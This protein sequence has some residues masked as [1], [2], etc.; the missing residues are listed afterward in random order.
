MDE[1]AGI[2]PERDA[3]DSE[4]AERAVALAGVMLERAR[5]LDGQAPRVQRKRS[6]RLRLLVRNPR[7]KA[8]AL[9]LSDELMR[10]PD[11][12]R[13]ARRFARLVRQSDVSGFPWSDRVLLRASAAGAE[14]APWLVTPLV[15]S[16][17]RAES[18][19]VILDSS[20]PAFSRHLALRRS[21]G[22]RLNVNVLGEAILGAEE[23][24]AR[25]EQVLDRLRHP[26]V[27][28]VSVKISAI[29]PTV[30]SL[31]FAATVTDVADRLRVLY[32]ACQAV[33]P[34][35][36]VNLDMEEYRDLS[37]TAAAFTA[38]LGEQEFMSLEAGIALQAYLPD[39]HRVAS[40]VVAWARR[41][42]ARG[43]APVKIRL[44][45]GANL[46][47]ERVESELRGWPAAPYADKADVDASY[48]R[49]LDML[50]EPVNDD[51]IR[52]GLASHNLFDVAWGLMLR[53]ELRARGAEGRLEIE[54]L[55]GMAPSQ[56]S[57]ASVL[58]GGMLLYA[59]VAS[60]DDFPAAV[61]YLVRRLDENTLP[62][63]FL[64]HV[65]T[66]RA[67]DD[68]FDAEARRFREAVA[69]RSSVSTRLRRRQDRSRPVSE[70]TPERPFWNEPDTDFALAPNRAWIEDH[71]ARPARVAPLGESDMADIE[72]AVETARSARADWLRESLLGRAELLNRVGDRV[73]A[74]RGELISAMAV[75]NGKTVPEADTEV[76]EAADLA[77]YYARRLLELDT[78]RASPVPRG[79]IVV[80]PP[81]NFPVAI[82]LG[83][84]I[85][86]LAA[87]STVILKPAPEAVDLGWMV[88]SLCWEA[89]IPEHVVQVVR[90]PDNDIG[91]RL[92]THPDVNGVIL[93]GSADT[94]RRFLSWRPDLRLHGE[95]SGKNAMVITSTADVDLAIR[96]LVRSAFGHAGQ[97]CSAA[98]LAIV[99]ARLHDD[100]RFLA[101]LADATSTLRVGA[102]NDLSTDLSPVIGPPSGPLAQALTEL[103]EGEHWL[104]E[105]RSMS[106]DGRL[107]SPGVR[108]GVRPGSWFHRTECFGPVL[109]VMRADDLRHAVAL[110]N[111]VDFGLTAG[112]HALDPDEITYWLDHVEAGNLYV[113][114]TTTG[115]IVRRQPFGGWKRSVVGPTAKA[116]G[117]NYVTRLVDWRDDGRQPL[118]EAA[119]SFADWM[120]A[121]GDAEADPSGLRAERNIF[122]YR[123]L[124]RGVALRVA[125]DATSRAHGIARLAAVATRARVWVSSPADED[126]AAFAERLRRD[127]VDRVRTIG[128]VGDGLRAAVHALMIPLDE[129]EP[130]A[131]AAIEL[132]R[133]LH[134]Q[135]V[136]VT[137]HRHGLIRD[138]AA[139]VGRASAA[140]RQ[141]RR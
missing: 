46:A 135:A 56:S 84:V 40:D 67:G 90:C 17:V 38:V 130:V 23:A 119:A 25:L 92:I 32:R 133:W 39:T 68:R 13:A 52:V 120:V 64:T 131:D 65:P 1:S 132:P 88:A 47:M 85:A 69:R 28:Y 26:D 55:E 128:T 61:A 75:H 114:R 50:L 33:T 21:E 37:L 81:W 93:T 5:T 53:D 2:D 115:A 123:P 7:A 71:L 77:R 29:A 60:R 107:W 16:R 83:G 110:Q 31:A 12:R 66:M 73:C 140:S 22:M 62:E 126:E 129:A 24:R 125:D 15:R 4:R 10:I 122:R 124:G 103:G 102:A 98:S 137:A 118:D 113:N 116:G 20:D 136:S 14:R 74:N 112:L 76:S 44:V 18:E 9:A 141:K 41:R 82:P 117:P 95:T 96:D 57:V 105:P 51:A 30:S 100:P 109:G 86:A 27:D 121:E 127:P 48:K 139:S 80:A 19:G 6:D 36:F 94:A 3:A 11:D 49:L 111:G 87:G 8:F 43:G 89:G 78:H 63:N 104:V 101:R 45:K 42:R 58:A 70:T 59:P 54:M 99:E 91:R 34:A 79:T 97:K 108:L 106:S 72:R 138:A 134:E 35:K